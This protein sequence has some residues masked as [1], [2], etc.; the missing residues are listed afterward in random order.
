MLSHISLLVER[1]SN[2]R[3]FPKS[4]AMLVGKHVRLARRELTDAPLSSM[5][6]QAWQTAPTG[7][8]TWLPATTWRL[9]SAAG[10]PQ[11]EEDARGAV[12]VSRLTAA[13]GRGARDGQP[14]Q[15]AALHTARGTGTVQRALPWW[16]A[17][18]AIGPCSVPPFA[19]CEVVSF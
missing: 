8:E 12:L 4:R 2:E 18:T 10:Q 11:E 15:R 5:R 14:L 9:G 19:V 16:V 17:G 13:W 1:F 6:F 7:I 3:S